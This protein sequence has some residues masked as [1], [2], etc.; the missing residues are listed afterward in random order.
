VEFAE[1]KSDSLQGGLSSV[2]LTSDIQ[3]FVPLPKSVTPSRIE[4][5]A[6]IYDFELTEEEMAS[7]ETGDYAPCSWDP[8]VSPLDN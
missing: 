3:S 8:A 5:N 7:L 4:S 2:S 1:G 6:D